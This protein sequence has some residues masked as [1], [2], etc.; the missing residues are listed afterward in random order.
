[1]A[2]IS[3]EFA[4]LTR[5]QELR[6]LSYLLA[7]VFTEAANQSRILLKAP[8]QSPDDDNGEASPDR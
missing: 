6:F 3:S 8:P 1:V 4:H 7:L 2:A 5:T